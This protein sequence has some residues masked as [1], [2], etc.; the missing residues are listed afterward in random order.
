MPVLTVDD[1]TMINQTGAIA[2]YLA[3]EFGKF[4]LKSEST[5]RKL[6]I[7]KMV[8]CGLSVFFLRCNLTLHKRVHV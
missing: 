6:L 4:I 3:R 7:D 2:R 8:H 1:K 5:V